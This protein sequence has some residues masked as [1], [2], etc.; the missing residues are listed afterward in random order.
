M[1]ANPGVLQQG[2]CIN[3]DDVCVP[4][5]DPRTGSPTGACLLNQATSCATS[6]GTC[7]A[8]VKLIDPSTDPTTYP[9][10]ASDAHCIS[11]TL[12]QQASPMNVSR[13]APCSDASK[14]CVP[15]AFL[16]Q[17]VSLVQCVSLELVP[18]KNAPGSCVSLAVPE[19]NR[20][21]DF[22]PQ[23]NCAAT[24][25][26]TPLT[27][28]TTGQP[29]G[30]VG[31]PCDT[32]TPNPADVFTACNKGGAHCVP[33]SAVPASQQ[34]DLAQVDCKPKNYFCIPNEILNNGPF[35]ACNGS[36]PL[37]GKYRGTCI[38]D[39]LSPPGK[40][41]FDNCN[42]TTLCVPCFSPLDQS[43]TNAPGCPILYPQD[44]GM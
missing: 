10:C 9:A 30:L 27:N 16:N 32:R 11:T 34:A 1:Q 39:A 40:I 25:R 35:T 12:V 26:C 37:V 19:V 6:A 22:L 23:A 2:A 20:E 18:G 21:K 14:L 33:A 7:A 38:N 17:P 41:V 4:C 3:A 31:P 42:D 15:D 13:L 29:T 43:K 28:P 24:E 44:Y 8:P 5:T 36:V